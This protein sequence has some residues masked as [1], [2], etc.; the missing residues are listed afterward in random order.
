MDTVIH[1]LQ[2]S[3]SFKNGIKP[4]KQEEAGGTAILASSRS[5][6]HPEAVP[7]RDGGSTASTSDADDM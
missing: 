1:E 4:G 2:D 5:P 3:K 6:T 7:E